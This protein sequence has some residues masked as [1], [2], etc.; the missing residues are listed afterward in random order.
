M[1]LKD[2]RRL[3]HALRPPG[4]QRENC[5]CDWSQNLN[6]GVLKW[7]ADTP[8]VTLPGGPDSSLSHPSPREPWKRRHTYLRQPQWRCTCDRPFG[9]RRLSPFQCWP[10]PRPASL[11]AGVQ[12]DC[13]GLKRGELQGGTH[14]LGHSWG[15]QG[16]LLSGPFLLVLGMQD[17]LCLVQ[18]LLWSIS[19][20]CIPI[21]QDCPDLGRLSLGHSRWSHHLQ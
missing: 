18:W 5:S 11:P 13:S 6:P 15:P 4:T 12:S 3:A 10:A 9:R 14:M 2:V 16:L 1:Y 8:S 20:V 7:H 19:L 21:R 17:L